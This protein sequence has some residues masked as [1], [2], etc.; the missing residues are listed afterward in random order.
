MKR[1]PIWEQFSNRDLLN[2]KIRELKIGLKDSPDIARAIDQLKRELKKKNLDFSPHV[3]IAD[4]WFCP[5]GIPGIAIPFFLLHPRLIALEKQ[6]MGKVEGEKRDH[7]MRLL[8]HEAGHA[9]DNAFK[10]KKDPRRHE[11]F[12]NPFADYP[13]AYEPRPYSKNFV[14]HLEERYAQAHPEEDWAE[15]F[16]VWLTPASNWRTRYADW[17]ALKKLKLMD[18]LMREIKGAPAIVH[19]RRVLDPASRDERT[20]REYYRQKRQLHKKTSTVL[21]ASLFRQLFVKK[22]HQSTLASRV[23]RQEKQQIVGLVAKR[24]REQHHRIKR[25]LDGVIAACE[26]KKLSLARPARVTKK[27][28]VAALARHAPGSIR[29]GRHRIVM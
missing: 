16:A 17:S 27:E 26:Q 19:N 8:R 2:L 24:T 14:V 3:W 9:I 4:E 6:M 7:F 11:V 15:T 22:S 20:L 13:M 18:R 23:L 1:P 5:D 28:L 21:P 29:R 10:L 12:G 25:L